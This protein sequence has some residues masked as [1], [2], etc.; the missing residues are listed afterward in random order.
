VDDECI[1]RVFGM[2]VGHT[3]DPSQRKACGCVKSKDKRRTKAYMTRAFVGASLAMR[4]T[5][6]K[7]PLRTTV[8][9]ILP[10]HL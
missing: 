9:T 3:E 4:P 5:A 6:L 7:K 10:G 1:A 2:D 8:A